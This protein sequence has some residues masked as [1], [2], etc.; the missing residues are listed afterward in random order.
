MKSYKYKFILW[1]LISA[2]D[3]GDFDDITLEVVQNHANSGTISEF[4][5]EKFG[6]SYDFSIIDAGDWE[7]IGESWRR[8]ANAIDPARKFGVNSK[9]ICLL[10]AYALESS[11][12]LESSG[13]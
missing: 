11:Q 3:S 9:G 5:I 4:M 1:Q 7:N 6:S 12:M 8:I 2:C 10:M 13:A